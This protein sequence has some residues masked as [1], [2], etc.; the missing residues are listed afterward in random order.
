MTINVLTLELILEAKKLIK[1]AEPPLEDC[2]MYYDLNQFCDLFS[3]TKAEG[4]KELKSRG[5]EERGDAWFI[6][7]K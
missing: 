6:K 4:I 5:A 2:G 7:W 3:L 1:A